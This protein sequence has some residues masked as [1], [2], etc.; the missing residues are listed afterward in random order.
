M[1][2]GLVLYVGC[3]FLI[4]RD[5]DRPPLSPGSHFIW[6]TVAGA[7]TLSLDECSSEAQERQR[8]HRLLRKVVEGKANKTT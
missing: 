8:R 6:H 5:F 3:V 2:E 1:Q 4:L 7:N